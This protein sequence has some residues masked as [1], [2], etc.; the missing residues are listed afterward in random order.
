MKFIESYDD[1]ENHYIITDYYPKGSLI[2]F[3]IIRESKGNKLT[4]IEIKYYV[5]QIVN[6]LIYLKKII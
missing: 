2:D 1:S 5:L 3:C 4:E 6:A